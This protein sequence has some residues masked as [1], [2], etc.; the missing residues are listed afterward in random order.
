MAICSP[1]KNATRSRNEV[2]CSAAFCASA[3]RVRSCRSISALQ[4]SEAQ[5]TPACAKNPASPGPHAVW[6]A[7]VAATASAAACSA[8][9]ASSN[10]VQVACASPRV[11]RRRGASFFS[12]AVVARERAARHR[13]RRRLSFSAKSWSQRRRASSSGRSPTLARRVVLR[14]RLDAARTLSD[15]RPRGRARGVVRDARVANAAGSS[16][17]RP[18]RPQ[19]CYVSRRRLHPHCRV[20]LRLDDGRPRRRDHGRRTR[21]K[22]V[23]V[24]RCESHEGLAA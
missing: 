12:T 1:S 24:R 16:K 2:I 23:D 6:S 18:P 17:R 15:A 22:C 7:A 5:R 20:A 9:V 14:R 13:S 3:S 4:F 8:S 10:G 21:I 11:A 19:N